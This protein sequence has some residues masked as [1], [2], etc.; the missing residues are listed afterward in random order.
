MPEPTSEKNRRAWP[1]SL[2]Q[3]MHHPASAEFAYAAFANDSE[4]GWTEGNFDD[5]RQASDL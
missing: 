5:H 2:E 3:M 1:V 4:G